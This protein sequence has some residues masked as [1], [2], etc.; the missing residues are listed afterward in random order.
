[1]ESRIYYLL[2]KI[3]VSQ[4]NIVRFDVEMNKVKTILTTEV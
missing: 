1:L 4:R 3:Q 2:N